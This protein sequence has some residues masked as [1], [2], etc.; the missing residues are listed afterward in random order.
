MSP[1]LQTP[2]RPPQPGPD[3]LVRSATAE[4]HLNETFAKFFQGPQADEVLAYLR[5]VTIQAVC[6]PEVSANALF[7]R[8]GMRFLA[9]IIEQRIALG[10]T[11]DVSQPQSKP[12]SRTSRRRTPTPPSTPT[13]S[14]PEYI[15][16]KFWDPTSNAPKIEDLGKAYVNLETHQGK[17]KETW[18]QSAWP[19]APRRPTSTSSPSR[20]STR[21]RSRTSPSRGFCARPPSIS[22]CRRS[23]PTGSPPRS[24]RAC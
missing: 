16:E 14:R 20:A 18:E 19:D 9:G 15:P 13:P 2:D 3:G 5:S 22:V 6:G 24:S 17:L 21:T 23:R 12:V 8:E 4:R 10:R 7:H 1:K 11:P